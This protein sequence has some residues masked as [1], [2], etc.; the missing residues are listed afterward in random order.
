VPNGY[1]F[2]WESEEEF[3]AY[4][5]WV[6]EQE[7]KARRVA[8]EGEQLVRVD[9]AVGPWLFS[10]SNPGFGPAPAESL[11]EDLDSFDDVDQVEP[12]RPTEDESR[13]AAANLN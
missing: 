1:P 8:G 3:L 9:E 6:S 2:G 7:A 4:E 11:P 10:W 5:R 12:Y 13:W